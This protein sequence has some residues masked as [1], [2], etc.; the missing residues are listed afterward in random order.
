MSINLD[1]RE[2]SLFKDGKFP[3]KQLLVLMTELLIF[4]Y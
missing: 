4:R 3:L 1:P 2:N